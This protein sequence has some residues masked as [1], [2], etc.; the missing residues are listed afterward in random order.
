MSRRAPVWRRRRMRVAGKAR[1]VSVGVGTSRS[2]R[3]MRVMDLADRGHAGMAERYLLGAR[4][5]GG[6]ALETADGWLYAFRTD[7][8]EMM[9]GAIPAPGEDPRRLVAEAREFFGARSRGFTLFA[10]TEAEDGAARAG[11]LQLRK[12]RMPAMVLRAPVAEPSAPDGVVLRPVATHGEARDYLGVAEA[13]FT[14]TGMPAGKGGGVCG[15]AGGGGG[16][17]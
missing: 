10:R 15:P 8:P 7:F 6:E 13:A 14:A 9:N 11:G 5:D 2:R 1:R 3:M 4:L 17:P 16:D 12:E